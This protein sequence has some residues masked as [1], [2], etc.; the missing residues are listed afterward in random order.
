MHCERPNSITSSA[1][2]RSSAGTLR[3]S[4]SA[5]LR[6]MIIRYLVG[7]PHA[8]VR[9]EDIRR[10]V[11]RPK[12]KAKGLQGLV[13]RSRVRP[14]SVM[15]QRPRSESSTQPH[16]TSRRLAWRTWLFHAL[17]RHLGGRASLWCG[18]SLKSSASNLYKTWGPSGLDCKLSKC[19]RRFST[20]PFGG[21][22][23]ASSQQLTF[24]GHLQR[25]PATCRWNATFRQQV[26]PVAQRRS[27]RR[28]RRLTPATLTAL[29][30]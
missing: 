3:C 18:V 26:T 6:L 2:A 11:N 17:S 19:K 29:P 4:V 14:A 1:R 23:R 21:N 5:T 10:M 16:V 25:P 13:P 20:S 8:G 15:L 22:L 9:W 12:V 28:L 27:A 30:G 24:I 7:P